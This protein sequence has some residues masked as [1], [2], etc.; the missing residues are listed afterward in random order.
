[1][2]TVTLKREMIHAGDLILVN[3]AHPYREGIVRRKLSP[4]NEETADILLEKRA[5]RLLSGLMEK[6]KGWR[7]IVAVSG[8]RSFREQKEIYAQSLQENGKDFTGKFVA[9]PGCSEHQTGLAVDLALKQEHIDFICP[10]FPYTGICQTFRQAAVYYGFI[11]RYPREKESV[12]GISHEPW[13][14]R[15][16]GA[17]HAEIMTKQ[18][19]VLEEYLSFLKNYP[20]KGAPYVF[21]TKDLSASVF[22]LEA[23]KTGDTRFEIED[24]VP[25]SVS[26]NNTDGFIITRWRDPHDG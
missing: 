6:L 24:G 17:P 25:Y 18:G 14:F 2:K 1:M 15:Y 12:T 8:W 9:V 10:D 23:E 19:F 20:Y 22:Y 4:V 5:V 11:E 26:G 16:V 13:H 21:R 7:Q 3:A